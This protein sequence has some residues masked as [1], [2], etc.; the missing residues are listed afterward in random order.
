MTIPQPA[1]QPGLPTADIS[2]NIAVLLFNATTWQA[3]PALNHF[4]CF[5]A[6]HLFHI[7]N[8]NVKFLHSL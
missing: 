8:T 3:L 2:V 5:L 6:F 4:P 1:S 7:I